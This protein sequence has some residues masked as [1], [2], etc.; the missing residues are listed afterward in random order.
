LLYLA[1]GKL[2]QILPSWCSRGITW[3]T[4]SR[5]RVPTPEVRMDVEKGIALALMPRPRFL[6]PW[7]RSVSYMLTK[8]SAARQKTH[9][10]WKWCA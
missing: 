9:K 10:S 3:H 6:N 2:I 8:Q 1:L 7:R 4:V 5:T